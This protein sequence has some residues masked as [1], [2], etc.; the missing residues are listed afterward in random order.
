M[1]LPLHLKLKKSVH[2]EIASAQDLIVE[3]SYNFFPKGVLHGGTAIW[4][5]YQGNRFSEDIDIYINEKKQIENFF[6]ALERKGFRILKKRLREKSLYSLLG[7]NH[8]EVRFEAT[9]HHKKEAI[10][11]EYELADGNLLTV[12]TL[13]PEALLSEKISALLNR[14]KFR[15]LYDIFFLLRYTEGHK[16]RKLKEVL[17]VKIVDSEL[18][19]ALIL[20]G[21][22]PTEKQMKEYIARWVK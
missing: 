18:L 22:V 7:F 15:D 1:K 12:Y 3:E 9:F 20:S 2:R 17:K 10:L 4:R 11:K 13:S 5:C 8:V 6:Q 19:P 14:R 16:P 21:P